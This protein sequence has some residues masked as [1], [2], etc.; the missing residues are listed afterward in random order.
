M[1]YVDPVLVAQ[2]G[3]KTDER[4]LDIGGGA[5]P[6]SRADV[7]TEAHLE[8]DTHRIGKPIRK[9][10]EYVACFAEDLPFEDS[11]FDVAVSRHVLEHA[12]D[13]EAACREIARVARR[14]YIEVPS[15]WSEYF[16][17]YPPHRWMISVENDGLVF[18]RRPFVRSPFL[19]CLRWMEY[20]DPDFTFRWN[21]E[22]RNLITTQFPWEGEIPCHVESGPGFDYEDPEQA[23]ESHLSFVIN[24]LRAGGVPPSELEYEIRAALRFQPERAL[25][26]NTLGIVL[27][28]AKRY[29]EGWKV[30][31]EA[32]RLEPGD[33]VFRHN[34]QLSLTGGQPQLKLLP[35]ELLDGGT[36]RENFAGPVFHSSSNEYDSLLAD[37]MRINDGEM[38]LD[39]INQGHPFERANVTVDITG[40][41][42][43]YRGDRKTRRSDCSV[44]SGSSALPFLDGSLDVAITRGVLE[45]MD[46]PSKICSELQRTARRGFIEVPRPCWEYLCGDPTHRWLCRVENGVLVFRRKP[47]AKVPFKGVI[48]PLLA[49]LPELRHRFEVSL[50]NLTF[51]QFSWKDRFHYRVE[52]DP[53]CPYDYRRPQDAL[54]AHLDHG[55]NLCS[56]GAATAALP[57][58]DSVLAIDA[59]HPDGLNL[60]GVIAWTLGHRDEG[61]KFVRRAAELAPKNKTIADNYRFMRDKYAASS[62]TGKQD[63]SP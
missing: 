3:I 1:A 52:D 18:R 19:N 48:V 37:Q 55:F 56:Q 41:V 7:V 32:N 13:P 59:N 38:V 47:F 5:V 43:T 29:E 15:P 46:D 31:R 45:H 10:K 36:P 20:R 6:F 30:F 54:L 62:G 8:D 61:L 11:E 35:P 26:L 33:E 14:G 49:K 24:A 22:H 40:D 58:A 25:A 12:A 63:V 50:R 34:A 60:R 21:L 28:M 57:E 39:I 17:G 44:Y 27:W 16:Y 53:A 9:D 4:V 2:L 42:T 51:I 23:A